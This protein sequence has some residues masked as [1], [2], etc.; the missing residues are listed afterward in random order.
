MSS[1]AISCHYHYLSLLAA[2]TPPVSPAALHL[3][4]DTDTCNHIRNLQPHH[5]PQARTPQHT[6]QNTQRITKHSTSPHNATQRRTRHLL[7]Q[8][9]RRN[10]PV[11]DRRLVRLSS[12]A[13]F[14]PPSVGR[15]RSRSATLRS[16]SEGANC[17]ALVSPFSDTVTPGLR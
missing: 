12:R 4:L 17:C 2:C 13:S 16:K 9:H 1:V 11:L 6:A 15:S 8:T 7:V 14:L 10:L 3:P 5:Q